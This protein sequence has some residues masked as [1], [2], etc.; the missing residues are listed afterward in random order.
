MSGLE[1]LN[2][3]FQDVDY[4]FYLQ[5]FSLSITYRSDNSLFVTLFAVDFM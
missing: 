4:I 2:V 1:Y 3:A 5:S